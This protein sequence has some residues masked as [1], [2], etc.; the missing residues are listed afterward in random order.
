MP[1]KSKTHPRIPTS[2]KIYDAI[3]SGTV[4]VVGLGYVGLPLALAAEAR[5]YFVRGFDIDEIKIEFLKKR[6][7]NYL[8]QSEQTIFKQSA[9]SISSD[10]S[11]LRS[12]ETIVITVPTPVKEDHT[13]DLQPLRSACLTVGE[14]VSPGTFIVVESTVNPG[15]CEKVAIPIIEMASH[16]KCGVDFSF[17]HAP[18]RVNP[19]DEKFDVSNI[20]RVVGGFDQKSLSRAVAFYQGITNAT[21]TPMNSIKEAEAVKMVENSFRDI[22]IAFVNELAM[23]FEKAGIDVVNVL[24]GAATKPFGFMAFY[25]GCGVG[26]H[27]IPVDPYYLIHYGAENGFRHRF[28]A[29]ARRINRTM[30]RHTIKRL[31]Q[32]LQKRKK[33]LST[34]TVALLGLSYKRDIPDMRESP[35]LDIKNLLVNRGATVRVFEPYAPRESSAES[36]EDALHGADAAILATDHTVFGSITPS[37]LLRNGVTILIDGKNFFSKGE[38]ERA[39]IIYRGIGR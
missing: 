18:E 23:S 15:A 10:P 2:E 14:H 24:R 13:P 36:V 38:Y 21:V 32:A 26:G 11:I 33:K 25:P 27:C 30:P 37:T 29:L 4:A 7:V 5:G 1:L 31:A 35:A 20:P 16:L 22:N 28:L 6:E 8:N 39:G 34:S 17:A 3:S 12:A 19:G 9:I